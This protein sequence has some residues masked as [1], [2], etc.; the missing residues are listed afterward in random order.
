MSD[1]KKVLFPEHL[2][3]ERQGDSLGD[4]E[5]CYYNAEEHA[6]GIARPGAS[7]QVAVYKYVCTVCVESHVVVTNMYSRGDR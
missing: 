5:R 2:F 6:D 3:V 4:G 1:V 7:K